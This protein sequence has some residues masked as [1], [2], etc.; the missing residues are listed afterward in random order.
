MITCVLLSLQT[1]TNSLLTSLIL[2]AMIVLYPNYSVTFIFMGLFFPVWNH[3]IPE[4]F[5]LE[6]T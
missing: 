4:W 5:G 6:R 3:R 1:E 2:H